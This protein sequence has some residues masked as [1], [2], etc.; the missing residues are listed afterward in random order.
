MIYTSLLE[1]NAEDKPFIFSD[2]ILDVRDCSSLLI[3]ANLGLVTR[4]QLGILI[5][6]LKLQEMKFGNNFDKL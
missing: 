6:Q 1:K 4:S 2:N 5:E 3:I